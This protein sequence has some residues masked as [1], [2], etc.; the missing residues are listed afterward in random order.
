MDT[1]DN[2]YVQPDNSLQLE[3]DGRIQVISKI[4]S[5]SLMTHLAMNFKLIF[6][7]TR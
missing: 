7:L 1:R 3:I 6:F 4:A 2:R 5:N